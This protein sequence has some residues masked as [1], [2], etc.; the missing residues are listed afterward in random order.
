MI[1]NIDIHAKFKEYRIKA[2]S[3]QRFAEMQGQAEEIKLLEL[4]C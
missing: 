1:E 3:D 4:Q 2:E